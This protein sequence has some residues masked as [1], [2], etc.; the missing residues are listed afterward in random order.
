MTTFNFKSIGYRF[1]SG[2]VRYNDLSYVLCIDPGLAEEQLPHTA[3]YALDAG[4]WCMFDI[5]RWNAHSICI[6]QSPKD[7]AVALGEHGNI[8]VMG[9]DDDYD[10]QIACPGV[11]LS[12]MREIRNIGGFAYVCGMDRQV[13][14]R[15]SPGNWMVLHGDM[16]EQPAKDMVFGFESIHG[17]S[18]QDIYAVG[19]YGEIWHF[20]GKT[21]KNCASPTNINLT[22]VCCADDGW[23][24]ACG[25]HG[26]LLKGKNDQWETIDQEATD[27][28]LWD[29]EWFAG[30]LYIST[31]HALYWLNGD[32]LEL[33]DFGDLIPNSCHSLSSADGLLWSIGENDILAFDGTSW[34]RVE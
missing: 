25:M 34:A 2:A 1:R 23:V 6:T 18:E 5:G 3:F 22:R 32:Q 13:F 16:P 8:R 7:Q 20:D 24:Y 28:D 26:I 33:V 4:D 15:E 9:N 10:E 14:K 30:K 19:W 27:S 17:Y 12:I 11:T 29:L 21:W 31:L